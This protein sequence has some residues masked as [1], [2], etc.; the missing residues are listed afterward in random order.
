MIEYILQFYSKFVKFLFKITKSLNKP[1]NLMR[2]VLK[3][4]TVIDVVYPLGG[5]L[6]YTV[7]EWIQPISETRLPGLASLISYL[8]TNF[9]RIDDDSIINNTFNITRKIN[10]IT[11]NENFNYH[12]HKQITQKTYNETINQHQQFN[13][14][15][16]I[17]NKNI[18]HKT[19]P[20]IINNDNSYIYIKQDKTLLNQIQSLQT[21]I[22]NLQSQI[23][24]L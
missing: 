12:T 3:I 7:K 6:T 5:G 14:N 10:N 8:D 17:T 20:I 4:V 21:Q 2:K 19:V 24:D 15:K 16:N 18:T 9:R 1:W 23:D 11:E 13:Y 22:N